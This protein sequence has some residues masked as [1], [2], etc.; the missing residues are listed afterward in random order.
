MRCQKT[1]ICLVFRGVRKRSSYPNKCTKHAASPWGTMLRMRLSETHY[2]FCMLGT[3]LWLRSGLKLAFLF[4]AKLRGKFFFFLY[5]LS[6][7]TQN[8]GSSKKGHNLCLGPRPRIFFVCVSFSFSKFC[9]TSWGE[10]KQGFQGKCL[11]RSQARFHELLAN[12]QRSRRKT[13]VWVTGFL[14]KC[15]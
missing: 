3:A 10:N 9:L 11:Q 5:L 15:L 4:S 1:T 8:E 7:K 6:G 14:G 12:F 2:S 13:G